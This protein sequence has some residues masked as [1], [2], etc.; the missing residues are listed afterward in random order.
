MKGSQNTYRPDS[1][2]VVLQQ[3]VPLPLARPPVP[4][5][6]PVAKVVVLLGQEPASSYL[7]KSPKF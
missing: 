4:V 5:Y 2:I 7:V 1:G 6:A 3:A